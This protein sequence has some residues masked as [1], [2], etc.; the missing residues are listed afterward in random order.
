MSYKM[1][2]GDFSRIS[3]LSPKAL[4]LYDRQGLLKPV[5]VDPSTGYRYYAP[6][7]VI[8]SERIRI[9]RSLDMPLEEI[10]SFLEEK[11]PTVLREK[12]GSYR[13]E[14]E[15]KVSSMR[16][17]MDFLDKLT[18]KREEIFLNYAV[19]VKEIEDQPIISTRIETS[20]SKIGENMGRA[21]NEVC[22]H[23]TKMGLSANGVGIALYHCQEF[24]PEDLRTE[25]AI[26]VRK[27]D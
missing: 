10:R 15:I 21:F 23:M 11:D 17:N 18:E 6:I 9:L 12:L 16:R 5:A 4:R 3:N 20:I 19:V 26:P 14:L 1:T 7:Q 8:E 25:I 13:K 24:D 27:K 22:D 2:I